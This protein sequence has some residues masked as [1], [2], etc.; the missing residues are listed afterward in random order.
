LPLE[1]LLAAEAFNAEL[2][3]CIEQNGR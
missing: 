1:E 3:G 2:K